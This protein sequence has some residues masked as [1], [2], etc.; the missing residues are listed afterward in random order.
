MSPIKLLCLTTSLMF[1]SIYPQGLVKT[2]GSLTKHLSVHPHLIRMFA[3]SELHIQLGLPP[4]LSVFYLPGCM[5][6]VGAG[7]L[8]WLSP[9]IFNPVTTPS[10]L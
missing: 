1:S 5:V 10:S 7:C 4:E 2:E 6:F 9:S 8:L 3:S